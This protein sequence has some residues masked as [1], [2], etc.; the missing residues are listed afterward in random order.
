MEAGVH[1]PDGFPEDRPALL[2]DEPVHVPA[3][4]RATRPSLFVRPSGI[5]VL[6]SLLIAALGILSS[7]ALAVVD[8]DLRSM[9]TEYTLAATNLAHTSSDLLR[10]RITITRAIE[11]T[12]QKEFDRIAASLP[13]QRARILNAVGRYAEAGRGVLKR[14]S[15]GDQDLEGFQRSLEAY[16]ASADQTK[17]LLIKLWSANTLK[18]A[19]EFRRQA[20]LHAAEN[21]GPKL[22]DA[23]D[24]LERLLFGVAEFGRD[25]RDQ[26]TNSIR[27]A[28]LVLV[29]GSLLIAGLNLVRS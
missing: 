3:A 11:A 27:L 14:G 13:D 26:G 12:T 23:S 24:A 18:E 9:Y 25:L 2:T 16:F 29:L 28:S 6:V 20:E 15:R 21:A 1:P 4:P 5:Q 7:K 17:V 8:Q 19:E 22:V 10:Y